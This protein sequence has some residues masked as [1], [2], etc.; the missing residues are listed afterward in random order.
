MSDINKHTDDSIE[1]LN[2]IKNSK[3]SLVKKQEEGKKELDTLKDVD[4]E[5][6]V[7]ES[8]RKD[9]KLKKKN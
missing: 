4:T 3:K 7:L 8:Q 5:A 6:V 2:H 9:F 1:Q